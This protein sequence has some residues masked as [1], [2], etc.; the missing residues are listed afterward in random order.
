MALV[1]GARAAAVA[2]RAGLH[3]DRGALMGVGDGDDG[4]EGKAVGGAGGAAGG[5]MG[6]P[7]LARAALRA[8]AKRGA[9]DQ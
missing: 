5:G 4:M 8:L 3:G 1:Q 9:P 7:S 2:R 6:S